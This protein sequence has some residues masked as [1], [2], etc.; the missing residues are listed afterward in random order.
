MCNV[1][2]VHNMCISQ[3]TEGNYSP[4]TKK[5]KKTIKLNQHFFNMNMTLHEVGI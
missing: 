1:F 3:T 4:K 5:R 2:S